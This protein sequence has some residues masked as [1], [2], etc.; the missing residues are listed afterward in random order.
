MVG[1]FEGRG[2]SVHD[3]ADNHWYIAEFEPELRDLCSVKAEEFS[4]LGYDKVSSEDIWNC[5]QSMTKGRA[6]LHEFVAMILS[7][8][9]GQFMNY[10]SMN[11]FKGL[12]GEAKV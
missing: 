7:L 4:L 5:V 9:V 6:S 2:S 11:A 1:A 10:E 12:I 8:Q 3:E